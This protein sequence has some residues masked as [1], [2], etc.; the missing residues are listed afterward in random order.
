MTFVGQF[1]WA[2]R[3]G[4]VVFVGVAAGWL[5]EGCAGSSPSTAA[6]SPVVS[7]Q[8]ALRVVSL[9][10]AGS[11]PLAGATTQ[12]SATATSSDNTTQ[13]VTNAA[14]WSSSNSSVASVSA[15]GA[16]TGVAAGDAD[17]TATYQTLSGKARVTVVRPAP[18]T[19][20]ISGTLRDGTSGGI[21]PKVLVQAADSTGTTRS[22]VTDASGEYVIS[23]VSPGL[24]T[25]TVAITSYELMT[26]TASVSA[27][28]SVDLV[29]TR[30]VPTVASL[31][32]D[33]AA[34]LVG[35]ISQFRATAAMSDGSS[36]NAT[37][38]ATW[39]TSS[40]SVVT[41]NSV[42]L[43]RGV[44]PGDAEITASYL[45]TSGRRGISIAAPSPA[46]SP[47]VMNLTGTWTG[48]GSDGLGPETFTWVLA[49][50]GSALSGS[51]S[52][53]PPSLTDGTCGSC[54]KVKDGSISGSV[55][56]TAVTLRMS[57]ALGGSQPT[58]TCLVIMEVSASGV[59]ST[60]LSS[61]YN[62]SDSCEPAVALGS[63]TMT[64]R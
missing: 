32:V 21:L 30:F 55:S 16:V 25:L 34:P 17:I 58:P 6:P 54:H 33:G 50:S 12:F 46:P 60:S 48:S 24:V 27:D 9:A 8:S 38:L 23:G 57:F 52:M 20:T 26:R 13:S 5:L 7:T 15:S 29:L 64:R 11:A 63:I 59:T 19:F 28:T 62:G 14:S 22:A 36:Q 37:N 49:Q 31:A 45:G 61:S 43:V 10:V 4:A 53:R 40:A 42:G 41:V 35:A 39:T 56:G 2:A 3:C 47:P 44:G 18:G 51:V 1:K